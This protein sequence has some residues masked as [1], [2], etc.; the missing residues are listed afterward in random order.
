M[1]QFTTTEYTKIYEYRVGQKSKPD[2]FC[3]NFVYCQ[4]PFISCGT[5][6]VESFEQIQMDGWI[7]NFW[8]MYTIGNVQLQD[9]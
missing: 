1:Q 2:Y 7:D 8:H 4:P 3:N 6:Y 5:C 9:I